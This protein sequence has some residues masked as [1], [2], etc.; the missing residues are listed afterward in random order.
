MCKNCKIA[1]TSRT[2]SIPT[3]SHAGLAV[4]LRLLP[5]LLLLLLARRR[6]RRRGVGGRGRR[7]VGAGAVGGE[8]GEG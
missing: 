2:Q 8:S 3:I 7:S 6:V 5:A 4:V 1:H